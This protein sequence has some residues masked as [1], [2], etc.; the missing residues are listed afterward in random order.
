MSDRRTKLGLPPGSLIHLGDNKDQ[1]VT[2]TAF[3]FT[4]EKYEEIS[5]VDI[6]QIAK[7]KNNETVSWLNIDGIHDSKIIQ[8]IGESFC[9]HPLLLE[10]LMNPHHRPK[11]EDF[12]DYL[13]FTLKMIAFNKRTKEIESEQ[14]S[15]VL[16]DGW[17]LSFQETPG[18]IFDPIRDRI[19]NQK[20]R[21]RRKKSDYLVYAL[22]DVIVD[23]YFIIIDELDD[24]IEALEEDVLSEKER[25]VIKE[26]QRLKKDLV[27]L[28]KSIIPIR[29]AVGN[30]Q[31]GT[32]RLIDEKTTYYLK[33][34]YDHTLHISDS[35]EIY[36][37][38]LNNTMEVHLSALSN[39][40]NK[41]MKVLTVISTIFMPLTFIVGI[42]GMNFH[43]EDREGNPLPW[44]MPEL[45][46]PYGYLGV[47]LAMLLIGIGMLYIL[48][49][50]KWM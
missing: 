31:K 21:V 33:D 20:G 27:F 48:R 26:I 37:E 8:Q 9:L 1:K 44:N 15:F 38:M 12:D 17:V 16:G 2:I 4:E 40:M 43:S 29:D 39:R 45:Y 6:A 36:R 18:D 30:L 3:D 42:Y 24:Q 10:D 35:I 7:Y 19:R 41:V 49:R 5:P 47:M 25:V 32:S 46:S 13:Y 14:V 23:H 50:N 34:V 28:R 11:I 22:I